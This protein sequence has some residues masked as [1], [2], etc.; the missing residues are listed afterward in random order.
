MIRSLDNKKGG[1]GMGLQVKIWI[2]IGKK[3]KYIERIGP[4]SY[5]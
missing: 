5:I 2:S 4:E 1:T 3:T